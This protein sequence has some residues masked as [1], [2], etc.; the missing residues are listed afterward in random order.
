MKALTCRKRDLGKLK[1]IFWRHNI[2]GFTPFL[3]VPASAFGPAEQTS[4]SLTTLIG[5]WYEHNVP[6]PGRHNVHRRA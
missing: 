2:F 1:T 4:R 6:V 5:T 3:D